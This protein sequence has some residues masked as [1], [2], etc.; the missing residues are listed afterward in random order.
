MRV[1][2]ALKDGNK[3]FHTKEMETLETTQISFHGP[4]FYTK[5]MELAETTLVPIHNIPNDPC[6]GCAHG[7]DV[8]QGAQLTFNQSFGANLASLMEESD[9]CKYPCAIEYDMV[10]KCAFEYDMVSKCAFEYGMVNEKQREESLNSNDIVSME[11]GKV[12]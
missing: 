12:A 1:E 9:V 3:Y 11:Q 8:I 5:E 6:V 10:N 7:Y 2:Q 4:Y